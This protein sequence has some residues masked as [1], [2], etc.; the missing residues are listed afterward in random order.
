MTTC[1]EIKIKSKIRLTTP[2]DVQEF[3]SLTN[4]NPGSVV[5]SSGAFTVDGKSLLGILSLDLSK[6]VTMMIDWNANEE[7]IEGIKKFEVLD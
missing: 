7:F 2:A 1:T 6:P 4:K 5:L 3:C